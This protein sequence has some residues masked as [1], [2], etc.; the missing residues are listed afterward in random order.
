[1]TSSTQPN[2]RERHAGVLVPLFSI[3]SARGWGIGEYPDIADF[4]AWLP[5]AGQSILQL[6]PLGE[7]AT[8][9]TSPY[10]ALTAFGLDP[11]YLALEEVEEVAAAGVAATLGPEA[12]R[13]L[14]QVRYAARVPWAAVRRLKRH[15]LRVAYERFRDGPYRSGGDRARDF[16][17][18][19]EAERAW[20]EDYALFRALRDEHHEVAWTDWPAPLRDR[21]PGALAAARARLD[22]AVHYHEYVQWLCDTQLRAARAAVARHG[23]LLKGDLPFMVSGDSADVW[24]HRDEFR[25][26]VRLGAPP[27]QFSADGQDWGLPV[28]DWAA[29]TARG[30]SWVRHRAARSAA[31][32]DLFRLDHV[33]GF[34]RQFIIPPGQRGSLVPAEEGAQVHLGEQVLRAMQEATAAELGSA[35]RTSL[36]IVAEDLGVVPPYVRRSLL[37]LGIPGTKVMRWEKVWE[38]P[39]SG[40]FLDPAGY[41]ELSLCTTGTHDT[42][43]LAAWYEELDEAERH[44][45]FRL[46]ALRDFASVAGPSFTPE[47][48]GAILGGVYGA[49]SALCVLPVQDLLGARDRINTPSTVGPDNWVYRLPLTVDEMRRDAG[50]RTQV[51]RVRRLCERHGRI[52]PGA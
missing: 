42:T 45:L 19:R 44:S 41:P 13:E 2:P 21:E 46:P 8:S 25:C 15:A 32:Y 28:Y 22:D 9:E 20:L 16:A 1:M 31:L 38:G 24:A 12:A 35:A 18:F 6:L 34:Y 11:S 26:D 14:D 23:V 10:G 27:D 33:V 3:R 47:A 52:V 7:T 51:E 29:M 5:D 49:A 40:A 48:H 37:A 39:E 17:R 4:A 36:T 30:L 43:T 50:V